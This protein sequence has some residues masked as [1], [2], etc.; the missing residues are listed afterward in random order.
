MIY[1]K[2]LYETGAR[3]N[4]AQRVEW[5]DLYRKRRKVTVKASKHGNSRIISISEDLMNSLLSLPKSQET[6]F[7][8]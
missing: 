5:T 7:M 4:E 1:S 8:S 6:F 2:F 3:V